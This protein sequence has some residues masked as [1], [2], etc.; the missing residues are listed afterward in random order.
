MMNQLE[1]T[2]L[3]S[4]SRA[5]DVTSVE[6]LVQAHQDL[7]Y[8]LAISILDEPAEAD[9]A[10]QDA[11]V[12]VVQKLDTFRGEASFTT[13][14]YAITLNVCRGRLRKRRSRERLI[15][16]LQVLFHAGG[17]DQATQH[18]EQIILQREHEAATWRA[19][20]GLSDPLREVIVLRYFHAL[21]LG[22]IAAITG[23]TERTVTNRLRLAQDQLRAALQAGEE[24]S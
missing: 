8:R 10:A 7:V 15:Q 24:L 2:R 17:G 4:G 23:V 14:L 19:I 1:L 3:I 11:L 16:V 13:W 21:K 18:P 22:D 12:K 20:R 6:A 9:E 5:G